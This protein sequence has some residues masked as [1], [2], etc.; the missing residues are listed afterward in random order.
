MSLVAPS[1]LLCWFILSVAI[2]WESSRR[3][4]PKPSSF[5]AVCSPWTLSFMPTLQQKS[6]ICANDSYVGIFRTL[7]R[8]PD[9]CTQLVLPNGCHLPHLSAWIFFSF[10]NHSG[11]STSMLLCKSELT[12]I[13]DTWPLLASR[14]QCNLI[15]LYQYLWNQSFFFF[16][17]LLCTSTSH[18]G[19]L[20][21]LVSPCLVALILICPPLS[22]AQFS[23]FTTFKTLMW[24][25][26]NS[27]E[28][29]S[30]LT[31]GARTTKFP[32]GGKWTSILSYT[33]HKN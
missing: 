33:L 23:L 1:N 25:Q 18:H 30:L 16:F 2:K 32:Y 11:G 4:N 5:L 12:F 6:Y 9:W 20:S 10:P 21:E 15:S 8:A 17:C 24:H 7:Y 14:V 3:Y 19:L 22:H 28:K 29:E 27:M 13:I 26:G 31:N